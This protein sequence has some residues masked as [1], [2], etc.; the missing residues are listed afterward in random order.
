MWVAPAPTP[1]AG[2]GSHCCRWQLMGDEGRGGV[3]VVPVA[4][5]RTVRELPSDQASPQMPAASV[6][7]RM[8]IERNPR[9]GTGW[10]LKSW[11]QRGSRT[12]TLAFLGCLPDPL[13]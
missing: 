12:P 4:V 2:V 5:A 11:S 1:T 7:P 13:T 8:R 6:S 10:S 9:R 3:P